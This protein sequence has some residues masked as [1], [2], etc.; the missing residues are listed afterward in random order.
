M[1]LKK[2]DTIGKRIKYLRKKYNYTLDELAKLVN[3]TNS[4]ISKYEGDKLAITNDRIEKLAKALNTTPS[5]LMGWEEKTTNTI[6]TCT[7]DDVN[8]N[9]FY[10]IEH[11]GKIIKLY[12]D[13]LD[14]NEIRELK[15]SKNGLLA[16][17]DKISKKDINLLENVLTEI[18][19]K[20]KLGK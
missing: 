18:Y 20:N 4:T 2:M 9:E 1:E 10:L 7:I 12:I 6:D 5:Y 19:L 16:F 15:D 17:N 3:V 14:E 13:E 11:K 8:N